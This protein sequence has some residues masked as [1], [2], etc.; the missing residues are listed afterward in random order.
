[1][2]T[3]FDFSK[4]PFMALHFNG[5]YFEFIKDELHIT[6]LFF[7]RKYKVQFIRDEQTPFVIIL[8]EKL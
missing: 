1:M 6:D 7:E 2:K 3:N 4:E 5:F 8:E